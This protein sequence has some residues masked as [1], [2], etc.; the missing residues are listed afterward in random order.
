MHGALKC[1]SIVALR[2][3]WREWVVY[4]S[5]KASSCNHTFVYRW[6]SFTGTKPTM[7][8]FRSTWALLLIVPWIQA[9]SFSLLFCSI[10]L[11]KFQ[12]CL[13]Y[14]KLKSRE[15]NLNSLIVVHL[16]PIQ[17]NSCASE[18]RTRESKSIKDTLHYILTYF[19]TCVFIFAHFKKSNR[20]FYIFNILIFP[21]KKNILW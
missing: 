20:I 12:F 21:K 16:G 19:L 15:T 5:I 18:C 13:F 11:N 7:V 14:I 6:W 4:L 3:R 8:T 9:G 2:R 17:S 10:N 1:Y